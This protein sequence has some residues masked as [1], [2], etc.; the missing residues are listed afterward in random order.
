MRVE[1]WSDVVCPWCYLG[2]RRFETA[3]AARP[4]PD[5]VEVVW[6]SFE[7]DPDAPRRREG[8]LV[9]HIARKYGIG[10]EQAR[11]SQ[12]RLTALAAREGLEYH[13][14]D[15]KPGNTLDAHRL[16]HWARDRGRQ[17]ALKERLLR[18]YLVEGAPIGE[19]ATLTRLAADVGLAG[20]E[21]ASVLERDAYVDAVRSDEVEGAALGITGV[22]FFVIDRRYGVAGAQDASVIAE[23]LE[24][25]RHHAATVDEDD[26]S[27]AAR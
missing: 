19:R 20:E 21:A 26:D 9:G 2:K 16:L 6:R 17:D 22:P 7:L 25:A 8:D 14:E 13:L 18:A 11:A 27:R 10:V 23:V 5:D 15:A 12:A 24:R 1:I 4:D 3:L